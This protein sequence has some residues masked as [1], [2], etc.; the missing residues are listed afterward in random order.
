MLYTPRHLLSNKA[1]V[2]HTVSIKATSLVGIE[3][4]C[5]TSSHMPSCTW[6]ASQNVET[7]WH[8]GC[9]FIKQLVELEAPCSPFGVDTVSAEDDTHTHK[10]IFLGHDLLHNFSVF[11]AEIGNMVV[12]HTRWARH[13]VAASIGRCHAPFAQP[14]CFCSRG[15]N[16]HATPNID[17]G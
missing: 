6:L 15:R 14:S 8:K 10:D 9:L 3:Q 2:R 5:G 16:R 13:A 7:V 11:A 4:V 17:E 12:E 1:C